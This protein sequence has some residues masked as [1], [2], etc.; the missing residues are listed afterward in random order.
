MSKRRYDKRFVIGVL[1]GAGLG[2]A[3]ALV[4]SR[5]RRL[6]FRASPLERARD[7]ADRLR[8][9][10]RSAGRTLNKQIDRMRSAGL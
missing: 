6:L 3:T 8:A 5:G 7:V 9:S 10:G 4:L 1:V 2:L